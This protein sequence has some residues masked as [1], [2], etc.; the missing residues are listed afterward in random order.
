MIMVQGIIDAFF[1]DG[2]NIVLIDYKTDAVPSGNGQELAKKYQA[3]L[4]QYA[5][6]L[7]RLTGKK[8]SEKIIYSFTLGLEIPLS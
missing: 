6:A 2:E 7:E 8:V 1:C 4:D 3:Q 5:M